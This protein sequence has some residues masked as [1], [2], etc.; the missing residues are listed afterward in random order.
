[1]Y[2]LKIQ[3]ENISLVGFEPATFQ[4]KSWHLGHSATLTDMENCV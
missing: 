4:I 3:N 1:M 2:V